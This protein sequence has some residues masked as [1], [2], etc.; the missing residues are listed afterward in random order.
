MQSIK[1]VSK[2][3]IKAV[4]ALCVDNIQIVVK[5]IDLVRSIRSTASVKV[6]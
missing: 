5:E 3:R 4:Q 1:L 6:S 2:C